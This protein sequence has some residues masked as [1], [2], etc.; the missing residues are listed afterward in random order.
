MNKIINQERDGYSHK[1]GHW[2]MLQAVIPDYLKEGFNA[3]VVSSFLNLHIGRVHRLVKVLRDDPYF[4]EN[5]PTFGSEKTNATIQFTCKEDIEKADVTLFAFIYA[6][7]IDKSIYKRQINLWDIVDAY[8]LFIKEIEPRKK[9]QT[10][11]ST[12]NRAWAVANSFTN[13]SG[14]MDVCN[15]C[16]NIY[17]VRVNEKKVA[18]ACPICNTIIK[19]KKKK[20]ALTDDEIALSIRKKIEKTEKEDAITESNS[21]NEDK[22]LVTSDAETKALENEALDAQNTSKEA[23]VSDSKVSEDSESDEAKVA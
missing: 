16:G 19:H 22:P 20:L 17:Y 4:Q 9:N 6:N 11:L 7:L 1:T 3:Y 15:C 21:A 2:Y 13:Q 14:E 12:I 10:I 18:I 8:K 23:Q 5:I